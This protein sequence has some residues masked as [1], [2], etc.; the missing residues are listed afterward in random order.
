MTIYVVICD[1]QIAKYTRN[2]QI[3]QYFDTSIISIPAVIVKLLM[4]HEFRIMKLKL[5]FY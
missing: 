1:L 2:K 5:Q 4:F 3:T